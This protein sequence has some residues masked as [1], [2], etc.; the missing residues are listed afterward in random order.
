MRP[1]AN[2]I[3]LTTIMFLEARCYSILTHD[4]TGE[5]PQGCRTRKGRLRIVQ[6]Q[7]YHGRREDAMRVF[8]DARQ[9][10]TRLREIRGKGVIPN[11][12]FK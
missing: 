8:Q 6:V 7:H 4:E 12:L 5:N 10:G 2:R 3:F 1:I 11:T 9:A